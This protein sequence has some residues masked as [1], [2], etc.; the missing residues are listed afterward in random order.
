MVVGLGLLAVVSRVGRTPPPPP[1]PR[2]AAR[3]DVRA[4]TPV[5]VQGANPGPATVRPLTGGGRIVVGDTLVSAKLI[6]RVKGVYPPEAR[7]LHIAAPVR[8]KA[9]I[10]KDG[11]VR[12]LE[13]VSGH[14][15]LAAAAVEAAKHWVYRP[16]CLNGE[17][18]DVVTVIDVLVNPRGR[19]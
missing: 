14:P 7:Q 4:A 15:L 9:L 3:A 11:K 17:P 19:P 8:L 6:K 10:G 18:V 2:I 5:A 16:T 12:K 13:V 1:R